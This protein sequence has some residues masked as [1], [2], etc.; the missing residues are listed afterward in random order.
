MMRVSVCQKHW[1]ISRANVQ[2]RRDCGLGVSKKVRVIW[3]KAPL[4][5][6]SRPVLFVATAAWPSRQ[7]KELVFAAQRKCRRRNQPY[8]AGSGGFT[9]KH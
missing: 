2:T 6:V 9:P 1:R 8:D 4:S 3:E 7:R 5:V